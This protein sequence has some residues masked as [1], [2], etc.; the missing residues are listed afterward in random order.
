MTLGFLCGVIDVRIRIY[1][2][3]YLVIGTLFRDSMEGKVNGRSVGTDFNSFGVSLWAPVVFPELHVGTTLLHS[4]FNNPWMVDIMVNKFKAAID[5]RW[6]YNL[7]KGPVI[8]LGDIVTDSVSQTSTAWRYDN[9]ENSYPFTTTWN[10]TWTE[11]TSAT[12]SVAAAASI[13]LGVSITVPA[14]RKKRRLPSATVESSLSVPG[15]LCL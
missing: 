3:L 1:C 8:P 13:E 12:L 14:R 11:T 15:R 5:K 2:T 10:Q 6:M 9:T 7:M 4:G